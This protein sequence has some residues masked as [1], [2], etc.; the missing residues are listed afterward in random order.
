MPDAW[1]VTSWPRARYD[2]DKFANADKFNF[3]SERAGLHPVARLVGGAPC[4]DGGLSF[5][6]FYG[7][8][9]GC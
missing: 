3:K 1:A 2:A 7:M 4:T 6:A 8:T 5:R 9:A